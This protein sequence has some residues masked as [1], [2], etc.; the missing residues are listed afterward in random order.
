MSN[1]N[2]PL[3]FQ[4]GHSR[5]QWV[6]ILL[7]VGILADVVAIASTFLQIELLSR[8]MAGLR[9]TEVEA[10]ANDARQGFIGIAQVVVH[11]TTV[12]LFLMWIH[13]AHRNLSALGARNLRFSS[14]W[15][16]GYWFIPIMN[17]FRPYQ[18]VKEIWKASD[19]NTDPADA[20][21]WQNATTSSVIGWW[22]AFW[23]I[24]NFVGPS[25]RFSAQAKTLTDLS[26]MSWVSILSDGTIIVATVF[27]I[28]VVRGIDARQEEKSR[29]LATSNV[30]LSS[31]SLG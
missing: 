11:L 27:A 15:A 24:Y 2:S 30:P 18:V 20:S 23:L 1:T 8:A 26:A 21:S 5:A 7:A 29:R 19:P 28:L 9:I 17:F 31:T 22:W 4:S 13:R 14:G 6:T 3:S 25:F 10:T 12:V 16:V